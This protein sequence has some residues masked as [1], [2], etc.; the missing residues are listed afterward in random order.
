VTSAT[1]GS[2]NQASL[3]GTVKNAA[4]D[5]YGTYHGWPLYTYSGDSG[6]GQTNGE[7]ITSF[8]GTWYVLSTS[9]S[10]VTSSHSQSGN[11]GSGGGGNGY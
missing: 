2:G 1:A 7:G 6:P 5:L 10:P 9:G 4:G 11:S 3:L 8:G